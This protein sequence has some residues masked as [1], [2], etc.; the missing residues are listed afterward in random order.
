[1]FYGL[2]Y[3]SCIGLVTVQIF[4]IWMVGKIIFTEITWRA[5]R[6]GE[7]S[8]CHAFIELN[9]GYTKHTQVHM[10]KHTPTYKRAYA[11]AHI[12]FS[13]FKITVVI[14]TDNC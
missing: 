9:E 11:H 3:C 13:S 14:V 8:T 6:G 10:H 2:I 4:P 12:E 7:R 1:M 5:H